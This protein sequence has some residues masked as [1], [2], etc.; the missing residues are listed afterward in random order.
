MSAKEG[1][2]RRKTTVTIRHKRVCDNLKHNFSKCPNPRLLLKFLGVIQLKVHLPLQRKGIWLE[3]VNSSTIQLPAL[4]PDPLSSQMNKLPKK[5]KQKQNMAL[6]A[7]FHVPYAY[8][9][10][11]TGGRKQGTSR[12]NSYDEFRR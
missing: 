10:C 12:E 11:F 1:D 4:F 8:L 5:P 9:I 3:S 2:C 7:R 6:Y